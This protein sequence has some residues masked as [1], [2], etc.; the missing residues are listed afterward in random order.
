MATTHDPAATPQIT[1]SIAAQVL[2][3]EERAEA[4]RQDLHQTLDQ[5]HR[6]IALLYAALEESVKLQSHYAG[7]LNQY[8][9][10]Q[11]LVFLDADAWIARLAATAR[12]RR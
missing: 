10:G 3:F 4:L 2:A 5:G 7:L 11:R 9:G 1:D 6:Q 8:D 12:A